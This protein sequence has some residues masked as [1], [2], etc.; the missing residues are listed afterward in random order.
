M[1]ASHKLLSSGEPGAGKT[2]CIA[3]VSEIPPVITD[4]GCTDELALRKP[5]TTVAFDYGELGLG[6]EDRLLLYGL[7]GQARFKFMF[8]IVR[9]G[10]L[11]VVVLVDGSTEFAVQGLRETLETY[12]NDVRELPLVIALNKLAAPSETLLR[13]CRALLEQYGLVA[14]I[15]PV[16]ARR[17]ADI[18]RLFELLFILLDG[19]A[20][21]PAGRG[22][23]QWH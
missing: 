4:V 10:L 6:G 2:P 22:A 9:E 3:A 8:D 16:D 19:E 12:A 5:T 21:I 18:V 17:R 14:P 20:D 15:L 11:G 23:S 13:Q 7:P 1:S